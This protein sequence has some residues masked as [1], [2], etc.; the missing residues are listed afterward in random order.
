MTGA[1]INSF[2]FKCNSQPSTYSISDDYN[3]GHTKHDVDCS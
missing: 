3:V 2:M 1:E